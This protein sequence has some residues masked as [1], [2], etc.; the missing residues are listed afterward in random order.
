ME[1]SQI[2]SVCI[3]ALYLLRYTDRLF[4]PKPEK[5]VKKIKYLINEREINVPH[6]KYYLQILGLY[7]E[8]GISANSIDGASRRILEEISENHSKLPVA[9]IREIKAARSFLLEH[10]SYWVMLN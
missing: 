10:W 9:D 6:Y 8:K 5:P 2:F 1:A 4:A 3:G 7:S